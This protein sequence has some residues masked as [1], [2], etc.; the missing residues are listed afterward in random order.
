[1]LFDQAGAVLAAPAVVLV[2]QAVL[3]LE[4]AVLRLD[5]KQLLRHAVQVGLQLALHFPGQPGAVPV[6]L[7]QVILLVL[8][9]ELEGDV[10]REDGLDLAEQIVGDLGDGAQVFGDVGF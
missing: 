4:A 10:L 5:V 6:N 7:L 3:G 8:T 9:A 1:M 2:Q